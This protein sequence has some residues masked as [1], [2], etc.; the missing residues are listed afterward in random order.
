M[1]SS[2]ECVTCCI[3]RSMRYALLSYFAGSTHTQQT[4]EMSTLR[5]TGAQAASKVRHSHAKSVK[6]SRFYHLRKRMQT[7]NILCLLGDQRHAAR[8]H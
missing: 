5:A 4:S 3:I 6:L 8:V 2:S 1:G 7:C